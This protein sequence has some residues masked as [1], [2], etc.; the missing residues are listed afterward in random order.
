[1]FVLFLL[2][3]VIICVIVLIYV[4]WDSSRGDKNHES[5]STLKLLVSKLDKKYKD[6]DLRISD[7]ATTRDKKTIL[8]C[9]DDPETGRQYSQNTLMG[10][11]LHELA[12]Y[13][14]KSYGETP[15]D[16]NEE[17]HKNYQNLRQK[18]IELGIYD[19]KFPP[20]KSYCKID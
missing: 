19:P 8:L 9:A 18:A 14:S 15:N 16:H 1:M 10:V 7:R 6:L 20:P 4:L 2:F 3:I 5:I 17:W 13:E 11:L 12:H